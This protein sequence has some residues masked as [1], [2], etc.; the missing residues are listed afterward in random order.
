MGQLIDKRDG[1]PIKPLDRDFKS[2]LEQ[3]GSASYKPKWIDDMSRHEYMNL[4]INIAPIESDGIDDKE[5]WS[6]FNQYLTMT[7]D[8]VE[9]LNEPHSL[10]NMLRL[11]DIDKVSYKNLSLPLDVG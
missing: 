5:E 1:V 4:S 6:L 8:E 7:F 11:W 2:L 9:D 3:S 10:S